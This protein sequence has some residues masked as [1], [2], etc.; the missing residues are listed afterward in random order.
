MSV[1]S[2]RIA[3]KKCGQ[4]WIDCKCEVYNGVY[5][6]RDQLTVKLYSK[7]A[8]KLEPRLGVLLANALPDQLGYRFRYQLRD[9]LLNSLKEYHEEA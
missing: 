5:M 4:I 2:N 8:Y 3:C 1:L 6:K 9:R 7:M